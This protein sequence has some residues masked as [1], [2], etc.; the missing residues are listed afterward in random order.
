MN[1]YSPCVCVCVC[2][3]LER[4]ELSNKSF[5]E[6]VSTLA[7]TC[8]QLT[9]ELQATRTQYDTLEGRFLQLQEE[10]SL[11]CYV[12]I[13]VC[14]VYNSILLQI[15]CYNYTIWLIYL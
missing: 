8:D 2:A 9:E 10:V 12:F 14:T 6:D 11:Y 7:H 3:Q 1:D 4:L 13:V 15:N 5:S